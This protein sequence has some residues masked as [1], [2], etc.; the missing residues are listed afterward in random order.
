M[1]IPLPVRS[2]VGFGG[3]ELGVDEIH[4]LWPK[5]QGSATDGVKRAGEMLRVN[6]MTVDV[7]L[8]AFQE[9]F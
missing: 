7:K 2:A 3:R 4:Y 5:Y 9:Q 6:Q 1:M 8:S